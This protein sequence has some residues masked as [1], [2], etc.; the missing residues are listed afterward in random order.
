MRVLIALFVVTLASL[1]VF[2]AWEAKGVILLLV[3]MAIVMTGF[4]AL[5]ELL[6]LPSAMR[7]RIAKREELDRRYPSYRYRW[8]FWLGLGM[9]LGKLWVAQSGGRDALSD[10]WPE[11][12]LMLLG[13]TAMLVWRI[14]HPELA[15]EV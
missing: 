9:L 7:A 10:F 3:V 4:G 11:L 2:V 5:H 12:V 1:A 6:P 13:L 14:K 15:R 8:L